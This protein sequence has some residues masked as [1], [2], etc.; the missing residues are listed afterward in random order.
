MNRADKGAMP[1]HLGTT[2]WGLK[3]WKGVFFSKDATPDRFLSQYASVFSTVEGNT[4]FYRVPDAETVQRWKEAVPETF[5]FCFKFPKSV[6]H[7]HLLSGSA[8][9]R[10]MS[11]LKRLEPLRTRLGPFHLQLSERFSHEQMGDLERFLEQLPA[12]YSYAVEVRHPDFFDNG[13][14]ERYLEEL[15]R[16]LNM[17]RVIFDTR[18]LHD[19][20]SSDPSVLEAKRKKPT[21]PPRFRTTGSR[22]FLRYVGGNRWIDNEAWL[23]EWAIMVAN[24]IREGLHP[25]IFIHSPDKVSAPE[26]ARHFHRELASLISLPSLPAWPV[27]RQDQQLGLF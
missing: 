18:R 22:P 2:Q 19:M 26:L 27:D 9:E 13:R 20:K 12:E 5:R 21:A 16:Q 6:T 8:L 4:T 1:Y 23:K 15:L 3:E 17:D 25:Y 10:A 24:W 11:F 7:E 14:Q